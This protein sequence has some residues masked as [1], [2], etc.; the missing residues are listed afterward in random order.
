[1][2]LKSRKGIILTTIIMSVILVA[3]IILLVVSKINKQPSVITEEQPTTVTSIESDE[4]AGEF[5]LEEENATPTSVS[6]ATEATP[7]TE[8]SN[9]LPKTGA[10]DLTILAFAAG[11]AVYFVSRRHLNRLTA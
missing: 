2:T 6:I 4:V 8:T 7:T 11:A 5:I 1:M 9:T 10:S 3:L